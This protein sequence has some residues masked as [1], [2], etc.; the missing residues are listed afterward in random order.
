[1]QKHQWAGFDWW[2]LNIYG[3]ILNFYGAILNIYGKVQ[4]RL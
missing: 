1:M 2:A 4:K 3:A